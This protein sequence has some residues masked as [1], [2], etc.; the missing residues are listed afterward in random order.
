VSGD[1]T[2]DWL[3]A[4]TS[5]PSGRKGWNELGSAFLSPQ[6]GGS[7]LLA[8]LLEEAGRAL[9]HT[10]LAPSV[11][12]T[13]ARAPR[14]VRAGDPRFHHTYAIC[15]RQPAHGATPWRV[16][17]FLGVM[18]AHSSCGPMSLPGATDVLVIDDGNL[19]FRDVAFGADDE[20]DARW[21]LLSMAAPVAT[22]ALWDRLTAVSDRL[23]VV[24]TIDDLRA[25]EVE[26]S[27]ELSWERTAQDLV[28]E[29]LHDPAVNDL[30]RSAHLVVSFNSA[31]ALLLSK[32]ESGPAATLVFDPLAVEGSWEQ[33]SAGGMVGYTSCLVAG[34][35]R[36]LIVDP[37]APDLVSGIRRGLAA[38]RTLHEGGYDEQVVREIRT[39]RFPVRAVVATL[40]SEPHTHAVAS[41][42]LLSAPEAR[43]SWTILSDRHTGG[44]E[45]LAKRVVIEGPE[46][47]L[48]G[49][50]IGRFGK[51]LTVDRREIEG[52]GS[53]RTLIREYAQQTRPKRPLSIAV[54]GP[55]GAGKSFGVSE[56]ARAVLPDRVR[57]LTFNC[58]QLGQ[59]ADLVAALHQVRDV[60]LEGALP[61]VFWDEFDSALDGRPL[62]WLRYFLAPMQDGAFQEG[63]LVHPIGPAIFVFAGGTS[64][65]MAAFAAQTS[66][67]FRLAKGP[68]FVSRLKGYV[69]VLGP[70]PVGPD[71]D[72][73]PYCLIR[74]AIL[75]RSMLS[76]DV[77]GILHSEHGLKLLDIDPGVLRGFLLI[78]RFRHGARSME[79]I[80]TMSMLSGKTR[81]ERSCLPAGAQLD[82]HVDAAEFR[83]LVHRFDLGTELSDR[84]AEAAH[85]VWCARMLGAGYTWGEPTDDY[86]RAHTLLEPYAGRAGTEA[87]HPALVSFGALPETVREEN[88]AV[89]R[90]IPNKL[91]AAGYVMRPGHGPVR[92]RSL[93]GDEVERLAEAEHERWMLR[94]L[95]NGWRYGSPR[96][97]DKRLHP[98][99][100]PWRKLSDDDRR[101]RYGRFAECIGDGELSEEEKEKDRDV[102]RAIPR[103]LSLAAYTIDSLRPNQA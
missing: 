3:V 11:H 61:L 82:L 16:T 27:R 57:P 46:Q 43:E 73:D 70:N 99:I 103:I 40:E 17:D 63:Q 74:R 5:E 97:D 30:S 62:G 51:L 76:R 22:G 20:L 67:A 36:A 6:P 7:A 65:R 32:A 86:L 21:V 12:V 84:L 9:V 35:A 85:V 25:S 41:V 33:G 24:T 66:D 87:A 56:V 38:M 45:T 39:L 31:G 15:A 50:P 91:A 59:P 95:D 78:N 2:L 13:A 19:G 37:D 29:L 23:V 58:S 71:L 90:D 42:P 100:L 4:R 92:E 49:V 47:T 14:S 102:V 52:Y 68:D 44:L 75:L 48:E 53:I 88:R 54:F 89:V 96:D 8:Q 1:V 55:P 72:S 28:G 26:V 81:Y 77:P 98:S 64:E 10:G 79:T 60:A 93:S 69:D 80:V 83:S 18:R 101:Q 94:H 34:L